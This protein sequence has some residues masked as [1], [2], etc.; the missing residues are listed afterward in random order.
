MFHYRQEYCVVPCMFHYKS[1]YCIV[2]Y[3]SPWRDYQSV[4][5]SWWEQE[6]FRDTRLVCGDTVLWGMRLLLA[7][8]YPALS[9][10]LQGRDDE[11]ICLIMPEFTSVQVTSRISD[12]LRGRLVEQVVECGTLEEDEEEQE[13]EWEHYMVEQDIGSDSDNDFDLG[14]RMDSDS[15][16]DNGGD[17]EPES[18]DNSLEDEEE[19]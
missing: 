8:A 18:T 10:V 17:Y 4:L 2:H 11:D 3:R 5:E 16:S 6:D 13:Q 9:Q 1:Q 19:D 7:L 15:D 12:L 14:R